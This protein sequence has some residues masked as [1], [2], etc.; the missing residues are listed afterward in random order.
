MAQLRLRDVAP[1]DQLVRQGEPGHDVVVVLSGRA[2]L[3]VAIG[4]GHDVLLGVRGPGDLLG[5]LA[6]LDE[7]PRTATAVALET[8]TAGHLPAPELR[9]FLADRPAVSW[10]LMRMLATRL[11]EA[12]VGRIELSSQ[13]ALGR[14][15]ARLLELGEHHGRRADDGVHIELG[16]TQYDLA[17]WTGASRPAVARALQAMRRLGWVSTS[18]RVIVVHDAEALRA[19]CAMGR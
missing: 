2:K 10:A 12:D 18:R 11:R 17:A 9:R 3:V 15:A 7:G 14:V 16:V 4:G 6:A 8:G 5:E 1:G 13:D 19:R